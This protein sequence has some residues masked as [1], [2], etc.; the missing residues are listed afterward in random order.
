[1]LVPGG[2]PGRNG[3]SD[4]VERCIM[5]GTAAGLGPNAIG[6]FTAQCAR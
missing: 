4:R 3:Y 6:P 1:V 5:G 2:L